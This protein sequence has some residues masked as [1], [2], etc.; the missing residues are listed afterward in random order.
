[1]RGPSSIV[2][3]WPEEVPRGGDWVLWKRMIGPTGG[4]NL[5]YVPVV[6]TVHFR[7]IWRSGVDWGPAP[8]PQ[9][10][11]AAKSGWW[12]DTLSLD[13]PARESPQALVWARTSDASAAWIRDV[14]EAVED[15]IDGFAW[16]SPELRWNWTHE[17]ARADFLQGRLESA[18]QEMADLRR[19]LSEH[20]RE[21][22][23]VRLVNQS[24]MG[25]ASWRV[26]RP[27]RAAGRV[28]R[29]A[30]RAVRVSETE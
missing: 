2:G 12:P 27:A 4:A 17:A 14:R 20:Q 10:L 28:L 25:S 8:L 15:V 18:T 13:I 24:I 1:V 21:L 29:T 9:W 7:A 26:T 19:G 6:T 23:R 5:A 30:L 11:E 22:A 16:D 3:Y